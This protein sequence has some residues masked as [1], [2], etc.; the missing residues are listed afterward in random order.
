MNLPLGYMSPTI[1]D[2]CTLISL[3][4][5]GTE[6][7]ANHKLPTAFMDNMLP[8]KL[9]DKDE[10]KEAMNK[11]K[12]SRNYSTLYKNYAEVDSDPLNRKPVKE[13]E[14]AAFLF[15]WL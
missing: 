3:P 8:P 9:H 13:D 1:L 10:Q 11:S 2:L 6:I 12:R 5:I 4:F 7:S 15:Y 14:H